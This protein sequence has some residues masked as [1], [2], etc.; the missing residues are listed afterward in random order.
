MK[1]VISIN[2]WNRR[3]IYWWLKTRTW[4]SQL[5]A[6]V[7]DME[8]ESWWRHSPLAP[9]THLKC[10]SSSLFRKSNESLFRN[11]P[12]LSL[13]WQSVKT[14]LKRQ[15]ILH[16][17]YFLHNENINHVMK[18]NSHPWLQIVFKRKIKLGLL[19]V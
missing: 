7:V 13:L 6:L 2:R 8:A 14:F 17:I 12:S 19:A 4:L 1:S 9:P 11:P 5:H 10:C 3:S 15:N 18:F 16:K